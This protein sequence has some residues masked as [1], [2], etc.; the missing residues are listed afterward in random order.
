M[1]NLLTRIS[2]DK[3]MIRKEL[4]KTLVMSLVSFKEK[5]EIGGR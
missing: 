2:A 4:D 5:P 1:P 3:I